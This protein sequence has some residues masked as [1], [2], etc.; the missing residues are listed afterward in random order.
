MSVIVEPVSFC[1]PNACLLST[2]IGSHFPYPLHLVQGS[3][4]RND[5]TQIY[6][7]WKRG[8]EIQKSVIFYNIYGNIYST[9]NVIKQK[10]FYILCHVSISFTI[11]NFC[12]KTIRYD[13][14]AK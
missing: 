7:R 10:Q 11:H 3:Y 8:M 14:H 2:H 6:Y 13:I 12:Q 5:V 1:G 4:G 9:E